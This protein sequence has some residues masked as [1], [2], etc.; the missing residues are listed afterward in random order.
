M[1]WRLGAAGILLLIERGVSASAAAPTHDSTAPVANVCPAAVP[2]PPADAAEQAAVTAVRAGLAPG[3][4][5][6]IVK[7]GRVRKIAAF[8]YAD[9]TSCV[10]ATPE[11]LFGIGSISKQFTA[12]AALTLVRDGK[13][14]L[15]TIQS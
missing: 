2:R 9:L 10:A 14:S 5:I 15:S 4:S 13:L 1:A 3:M 8:G 11:T 6:A 7:N 12:V